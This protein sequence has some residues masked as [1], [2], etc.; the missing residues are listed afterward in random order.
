M[1]SRMKPSPSASGRSP[2][3]VSSA[4]VVVMTR[5]TPSMLPPTIMTAPTSDAARPKP[6]STI[7][8]SEKRRSQSSVGAAPS[9]VSPSERSC[10]RYSCHAS[11]TTCRDSAASGRRDEDR[12]RDHHRRRREQNAPRAE[13]TCTRQHQVDERARRRPTAG[14]SSRSGSR[15]ARVGR[16]TRSRR[17][18][19]RAAGRSRSRSRPAARLIR[20]LSR[21]MPTS[22]G[23][24]ATTSPKACPAASAMLFTVS[25]RGLSGGILYANMCR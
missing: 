6:A 17:S 19:H 2:L 18:R 15:S 24:A 16:E 7:V 9:F 4:I 10:S 3:L 1:N 21:T 11:A 20:R 13:R 5:V 23:S 22:F 8:T 12:L 14:P 25:L